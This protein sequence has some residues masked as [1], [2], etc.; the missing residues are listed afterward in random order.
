MSFPE[1]VIIP[2]RIR[3]LV[4]PRKLDPKRAETVEGATQLC[5]GGVGSKSLLWVEK[6]ERREGSPEGAVGSHG[7]DLCS[8]ERGS[9]LS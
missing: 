9:L 4:L 5:F 2:E 3:F 6:R 1:F 8:Q 7:L